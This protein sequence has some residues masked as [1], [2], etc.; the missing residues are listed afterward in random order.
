MCGKVGRQGEC[1]PGGDEWNAEAHCLIHAAKAA[2]DDQ[3]IEMRR[4]HQDVRLDGVDDYFV[5]FQ[6]DGKTMLVDHNDQAARFSAGNVILFDAARP[7]TSVG[8]ENPDMCHC[9]SI[10][11]P[12]KAL[13]AYLGFD[14]KGGLCRPGDTPAGRLLLDLIRNS[15]RNEEP[16]CSA[17]N[18]YMQL[19]IYDLVGALFAPS[20]HNQVT[21]RTD[22]LFARISDIIRNNFAD[23]DFGPAQ[24]AAK[25]GISLR[26]LHKLFAERGLTCQDF[27][28][29][30]RLEH[31]A[32]LLRRRASWRQ[33]DLS[34]TVRT[35][36]DLTNTRILPENSGNFTGNRRAATRLERKKINSPLIAFGQPIAL[37]SAADS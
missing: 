21:R 13:V 29:S 3:H 19:V 24:A 35:L 4:G 17:D 31:A 6:A 14:P 26:Y 12:R 32:H 18:P 11:L 37:G 2:V 5:V 28:Y 36:A 10:N 27:V 25:S 22:K 1:Q 15:G 30:H 8:D 7:L 23:P 34:A 16:E 9:I 20:D 33:N